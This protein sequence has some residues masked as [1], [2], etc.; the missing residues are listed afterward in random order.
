MDLRDRLRD[1]LDAAPTSILGWL[2]WTLSWLDQDENAHNALFAD[3][4]SNICTM[5]GKSAKIGVK[6]GDFVKLLP[7]LKAWVTGKT[8]REIEIALEGTRD[9]SSERQRICPRTRELLG[10]L[11]PRGLS[12]TLGLI[13]KVMKDLEMSDTHPDIDMHL[14]EILAAAVRKGYDSPEKLAYASQHK[15]ILS[16]VQMHAAFAQGLP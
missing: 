14:V 15:S 5:L 2:E 10:A 3:V 13:S 12:F 11:I 16:P 4:G 7:A 8:I 9:S 1:Q 6:S